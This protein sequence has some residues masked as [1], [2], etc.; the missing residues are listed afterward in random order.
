MKRF[1]GDAARAESP[2]NKKRTVYSRIRR[3]A[4]ICS[5]GTGGLDATLQ[6]FDFPDPHISGDQRSNTNVPLQGLF[7]LNSDL[8]MSQAELLARRITTRGP[9]DDTSGIQKA[10]RLLFGR[11]AK[12]TEVKL[13]LDFLREARRS[14]PEGVSAWH[15][16]AQVLLSSSSF[17]YVE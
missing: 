16:Y 4:Y 14:S 9:G 13:G 17:Y 15:Q 11:A 1:G 8:V 10:Y 6:L 12:D 7:F 2:E 5:S 3:S